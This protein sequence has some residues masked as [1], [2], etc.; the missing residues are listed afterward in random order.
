[1]GAHISESAF[2][3]EVCLEAFSLG[4]DSQA[5]EAKLESREKYNVP[6]PNVVANSFA[7]LPVG[8]FSGARS[9]SRES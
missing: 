1:M 7:G 6:A 4:R 5:S 9:I 8:S 3:D 2:L